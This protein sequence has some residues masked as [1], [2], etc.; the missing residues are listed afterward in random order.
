MRK[1][2]ILL[3]VTIYMLTNSQVYA[4]SVCKI[5]DDLRSDNSDAVERACKTLKIDC[6]ALG[7]TKVQVLQ[8]CC[9]RSGHSFFVIA[10]SFEGPLNGYIVY[11]NSKGDILDKRSVGHI[12]SLSLK[13]F[14]TID[15]DALVI[16]A[17]EGSGTG[18]ESDKFYIFS[19]SNRGLTELWKGVSY[20][21][22]FL[23]E[24]W[25]HEVKGTLNF[26]D[27]DNDNIDEII[28]R[29]KHIQYSVDPKTQKLIPVK[30]EKDAKAYKLS[31]GKFVFFKDIPEED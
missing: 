2:L 3:I 28:H 25:N 5:I 6:G 19:M 1:I 8:P 12:R 7:P 4:A 23:S 14:K 9:T 21:K 13:S 26:E 31:T 20:E 16:D 10:L 17:I 30:T 22:S 15:N 29:T 24:D 11:V 27:L 18:M